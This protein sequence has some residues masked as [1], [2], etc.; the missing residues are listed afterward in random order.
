M[1]GPTMH[2]TPKPNFRD[3][4]NLQIEMLRSGLPLEAFDR[5]FASNGTMLANDEVFTRGAKEGRL[6]QEPYIS[7]AKSINGLN[8]DVCISD[9]HELCAFRNNNSFVT[10]DD[11]VHQIKGL[12]WQSWRDGQISEE[13]Y[14]DGDLMKR[15]ISGG[16]LLNPE[17]LGK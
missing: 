11:E 14:Y 16:I 8:V 10:F 1:I 6:K 3:C 5:F 12:C 15:H 9:A 2:L 17:A 7:I 4:V 13:R